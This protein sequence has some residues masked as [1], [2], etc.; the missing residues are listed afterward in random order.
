M[1]SRFLAPFGSRALFG[2]GDP[3]MQLQRE[4]NRLFDDALGDAGGGANRL[5]AGMPS[6]DVHETEDGVEV[7]AELPGVAQEDIDLRLD[8]DMLTLSGE[9]K[10]ERTDE[11][12]HLS[13]RSYGSFR[14]SIRLPF[15]PDPAKVQAHCDRGVLKIHVPRGAEPE[16]SRKIPIGGGAQGEANE[17]PPS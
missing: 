14:R 3:F 10:T 4:M 8:G 12:A 16:R 2:R 15:T 1:A 9:K 13:E 7:T 17:K 5:V 11:R 6:I